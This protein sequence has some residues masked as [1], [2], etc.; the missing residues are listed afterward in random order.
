MAI[1]KFTNTWNTNQLEKK[2]VITATT[3][4][5]TIDTSTR[6]GKTIYKFTGSGTVTVGTPGYCEV[7]I[8]AGGGGGCGQTGGGAGGLIY[9][10]S[11]FL[12]GGTL[13]VTVGAGGGGLQTNWNYGEPGLSG[14]ASRVGPYYAIG[15]GGAAGQGIQSSIGLIG[16]S[17]GGGY[18]GG[19]GAGI[20]GQGNAGGA[21]TGGGGGAGQAGG[22]G[23]S[24]NGGNGLQISITGTATYYAGG[25]AGGI[26]Q[27]AG[28]LGGGGKASY[29]SAGPVYNAGFNGTANTGGGGGSSYNT[30]SVGGN[31]GSGYIVIVTG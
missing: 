18:S 2:A 16:G 15:G 30:N 14:L 17:G 23:D 3:G 12:P 8:V 4:S 7:L 27:T 25:G 11:I 1:T 10:T 5:P 28:G 21:T 19:G 6:A 29:A 9:D 13:T 20:A 26:S 31:G 24:R 22:V